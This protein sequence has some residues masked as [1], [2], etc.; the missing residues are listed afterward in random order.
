MRLEIGYNRQVG[1]WEVYRPDASRLLRTERIILDATARSE[2]GVLVCHDERIH[3]DSK[4]V[5]IGAPPPPRGV[6][7][8]KDMRGWVALYNPNVEH[9][10]LYR[11]DHD[12]VVVTTNTL[13][14]DCHA[15][16]SDGVM[17]CLS[18]M[19]I[20]GATNRMEKVVDA[21]HV[22]LRRLEMYDQTVNVSLMGVGAKARGMSQK[23][24]IL[25][26]TSKSL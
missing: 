20:S 24:R 8:E 15:V 22:R 2:S 16:S 10:V 23:R 19:L 11:R 4:L 21:Q 5:R 13:E 1:L 18:E 14:V 26:P 6:I 7:K 25:G 12:D 3:G 9:W 17:H